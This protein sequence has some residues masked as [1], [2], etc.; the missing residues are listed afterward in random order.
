MLASISQKPNLHATSELVSSFPRV[1]PLC[2]AWHPQ[3]SS[4]RHNPAGACLKDVSLDGPRIDGPSKL[5]LQRFQR[6][7]SW[8]VEASGFWK[9]CLWRGPLRKGADAK[10]SIAIKPPKDMANVTCELQD[11]R[12]CKLVEGLE[13]LARTLKIRA[14]C[15]RS[16]L[17]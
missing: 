8:F 17:S 6:A 14:G 16:M 5:E 15:L 2:P 7:D 11:C 1:A 13:L 12:M 9:R 3:A 10:G 4:G